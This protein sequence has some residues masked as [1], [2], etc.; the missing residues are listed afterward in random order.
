MQQAADSA[1]PRVISHKARVVSVG[2]L[3]NIPAA[4]PEQ[5]KS[6]LSAQNINADSLP[7]GDSVQILI[8][9]PLVETVPTTACGGGPHR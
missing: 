7:S 1:L 4:Q 6:R 9:G 2:D 5:H 8:S 3:V